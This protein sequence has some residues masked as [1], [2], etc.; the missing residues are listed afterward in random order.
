MYDWL[1]C[2]MKYCLAL[3]KVYVYYY[4][5]VLSTFPI[6]ANTTSP[7]KKTK[8]K[9]KKQRKETGNL[10]RYIDNW[11]INTYLCTETLSRTQ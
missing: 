3:K 4:R 5:T 9:K 8:K 10:D 7:W 11:S 1:V 6:D 2:M